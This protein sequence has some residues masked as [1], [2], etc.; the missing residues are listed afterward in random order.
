VRIAYSQEKGFHTVAI[1]PILTT[2]VPL[3]SMHSAYILSAWDDFKYKRELIEVYRGSR[4][5]KILG[6]T[7]LAK[8]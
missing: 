1:K 8:S 5:R 7:G 6:D 3:L 2:D 4:T